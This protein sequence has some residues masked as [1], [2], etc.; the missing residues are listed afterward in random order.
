MTNWMTKVLSI[1]KLQSQNGQDL[2]ELAEVP[3]WL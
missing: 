1:A 2:N 3:K